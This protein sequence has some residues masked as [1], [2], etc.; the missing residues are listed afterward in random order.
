MAEP[1]KV[2][3]VTISSFSTSV[4]STTPESGK[5]R[6]REEE[7][8][9]DITFGKAGSG[10]AAAIG[11]GGCGGL[12]G[13][14]K[15][16]DAEIAETKATVRLDL[17]LSEPSERGS[18]EFN[19]SELLLHSTPSQVSFRPAPGWS[20]RGLTGHKCPGGFNGQSVTHGGSLPPFNGVNHPLDPLVS[21]IG[22]S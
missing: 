6:R 14:A 21:L 17:P 3:F 19:Y 1:R 18:A 4:L 10:G 9:V 13:N 2:P 7:A 16:D 22:S 11:S 12:F 8:V 5:K 20:T 15:G